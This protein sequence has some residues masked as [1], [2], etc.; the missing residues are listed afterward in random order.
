ML[1]R[2]AIVSLTENA[3]VP[4]KVRGGTLSRGDCEHPSDHLFCGK[5]GQMDGDGGAVSALR[6]YIG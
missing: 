2:H 3:E 6:E 5:L 4:A 1:V